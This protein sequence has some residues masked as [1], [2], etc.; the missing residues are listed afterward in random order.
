[1]CFGSLVVRNVLLHL[2]AMLTTVNVRVCNLS[3][4]CQ[5]SNLFSVTGIVCSKCV[6]VV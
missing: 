1:M 2:Q 4:K 6:V 3:R 5:F